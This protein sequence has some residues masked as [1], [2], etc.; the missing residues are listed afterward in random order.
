[1]LGGPLLRPPLVQHFRVPLERLLHLCKRLFRVLI[2]LVALCDVKSEV[3]GEVC[4][5]FGV[6]VGRDGRVEREWATELCSHERRQLGTTL[7]LTIKSQA[8]CNGGQVCPSARRVG[9][10]VAAAAEHKRPLVP[11]QDSL[12]RKAIRRERQ[13]P[14]LQGR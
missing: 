8:H 1:M 12:K 6:E 10:A 2:A 7:S 5:E 13:V 14:F 11:A 9:V 3:W 4:E